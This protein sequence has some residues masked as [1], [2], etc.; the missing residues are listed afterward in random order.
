MTETIGARVVVIKLGG[1]LYDQ[2]DLGQRLGRWLETR[3][4][5]KP[6]FVPGGGPFADVVRDLDS[7]HALGEERAHWL[8]LAS[9]SVAARFVA[10]LLPRA[11]VVS[12]LEHCLPHWQAGEIPVLDPHSFAQ[13]D[14]Q[15]PD[16]LPHSW[17]TTSDALA[18]RVAVVSGASRLILLKSVNLSHGMDWVEAAP[19][20][21]VDPVFPEVI[22]PPLAVEWLN[23]RKWRDRAGEQ[24]CKAAHPTPIDLVFSA[25]V[26]AGGAAHREPVRLHAAQCPNRIEVER[27]GDRTEQPSLGAGPS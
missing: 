5:A 2:P 7:T 12:G 26:V 27:P 4:L 8:A 11:V 23:F 3:S 10:A 14:E 6:I 24:L 21:F 22:R 16:C 9:L 13:A 25:A 1:S 20:G 17:N 19:H 18:A 15:Q